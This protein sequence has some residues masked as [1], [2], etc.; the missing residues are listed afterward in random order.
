MAGLVPAIPIDKRQSILS[1]IAGTS[2]AMTS[3]KTGAY[4]TFR[5]SAVQAKQICSTCR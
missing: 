5:S 1:G 2:P 4:A 3:G